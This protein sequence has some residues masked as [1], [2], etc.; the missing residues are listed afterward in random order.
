MNSESSCIWGELFQHQI[1]G[2]AWTSLYMFI[3]FQESSSGAPFFRSIWH[4]R[5]ADQ[6]GTGLSHGPLPS[7]AVLGKARPDVFGPVPIGVQQPLL[8][9]V[10]TEPPLLH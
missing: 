1:I 3:L 2:R 10:F 9:M 5:L 4:G 8:L 6:F 7:R